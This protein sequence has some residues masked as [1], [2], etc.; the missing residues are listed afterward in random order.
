M[1]EQYPTT[2]APQY[3]YEIKP[4]WNNIISQFDSGKE[5]R[6]QKNLYAKYDVT[7][8]YNVLTLQN[9]QTLWNFYAARRGTYEAFMFYTPDAA[10]WNGC[11]IGIGDG[12]TVAF[13]IPGKSTNSHDIYSNGIEVADADYAISYGGGD[14]LSDIVT[15]DTAPSEN[16]I[17]TCDFTGYLRIRCRFA[18]EMTRTSFTYALYKTGVKLKG[19]ANL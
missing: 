5:Q 6:R 1:S 12:T 15:F 19:V 14:C 11:Y 2:P 4:V 3:P 8:N 7:L 18:E 17:L 13:D 9:E 16:A 10:E